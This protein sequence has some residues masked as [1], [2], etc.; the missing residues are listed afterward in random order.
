MRRSTDHMRGLIDSPT[1]PNGRPAYKVALREWLRAAH[2]RPRRVYEVFG[3]DPAHLS[4][5]YFALIDAQVSG[6]PG[7]IDAMAAL[8]DAPVDVDWWDVDPFGDPFRALE[9]IA[10][11]A[12][13][14]RI[15]VY[16]TD[17]SL[18]KSAKH[19]S[20]TPAVLQRLMGW[21]SLDLRRMAWCWAHYPQVIAMVY[22]RIVLPRYRVAAVRVA[23]YGRLPSGGTP[24]VRYSA[25]TAVRVARRRH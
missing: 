6:P 9:R 22:Q 7:G 3:S 13:A 5:R 11:I 18:L 15:A 23:P 25:F 17:G 19:K 12:T 21:P 14:D 16:V 20:Y 8:D 10:A 4:T 1:R 24:E 2:G